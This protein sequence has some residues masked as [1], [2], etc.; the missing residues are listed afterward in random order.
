[1]TTEQHGYS[2]PL[3]AANYNAAFT[4]SGTDFIPV[5]GKPA[6][7]LQGAATTVDFLTT[8]APPPV[9]SLSGEVAAG[10]V[11][12]SSCDA[13][14]D[15]AVY[16]FEEDATLD[17]IDDSIATGPVNTDMSPYTYLIENLL[18]DTYKAAFTCTGTDFVPPAGKEAMIAI[19][20]DTPLNFDAEDAL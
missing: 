14:F 17:T 5:A 10:L 8:D 20:E 9:G 18:A 6:E 15:P 11:N 13:D 1:M 7:I 19:G 2:I 4:C 12:A 3:M 16:V